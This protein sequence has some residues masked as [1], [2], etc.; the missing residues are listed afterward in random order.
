[1]KKKKTI[2][3][4]DDHGLFLKGMTS[5]LKEYEEIEILFQAMDGRDLLTRLKVKQPQVVLLDIR[6]PE[7]DGIEALGQ[8]RRK[9]PNVKVI[10]LT[11]HNE[12]QMIYHLMEKGA[13][14]FLPKNAD[15]DV[16]V[17]AIYAVIDKGY[18]FNE[19]V[20]K[21]LAKG[22]SSNRKELLPF[23]VPALSAREIEVVK[24]IC[25]QLTV[26][27]IAEILCL[28][29]RTIETYKENIFQKTGAKNNVGIVFYAL[30][31]DLLE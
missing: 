5:L 15:I 23:N 9:Y 24:L 30:Q 4:V 31:Y 28:S 7:L 8:I 6:M 10:M 21:A 19:R 27:E 25:K 2:A 1:M 17:D 12:D 20:S 3:L 22:A 14:G 29:P 13:N 26:K 18:Y 11:Q 16:V